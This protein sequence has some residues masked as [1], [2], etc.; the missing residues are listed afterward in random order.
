[1]FIEKENYYYIEEF[2]KYGITAVYTKKI[3]GNMSD[4]C[5][6]E[7][8]IEGIQKKN[9]EKLL[10]EL[11]LTDKQEVMAFQTHSNNVKTI[12]EDT[13]KYYYEKEENY[14]EMTV[15]SNMNKVNNTWHMKD[16]DEQIKALETIFSNLANS[17]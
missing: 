8:Q 9:R 6:I 5:P 7:N 1:M 16:L 3:A 10:E 14:I 4:Y 11:N 15:T 17:M 2:E 12:G 13:T